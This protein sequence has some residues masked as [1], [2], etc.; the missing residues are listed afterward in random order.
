MVKDDLCSKK[1]KKIFL[2]LLFLVF[3]LIFVHNPLVGDDF[4]KQSGSIIK[5]F[6]ASLSLWKYFNG[7]YI[8]NALVVFF[9][10]YFGL[11]SIFQATIVCTIIYLLSNYKNEKKNSFYIALLLIVLIP[12]GIYRQAIAWLSGCVNFLIPACGFLA[13]FY[14]VNRCK[15]D[16]WINYLLAFL[17]SFLML[18]GYTEHSSIMSILIPIILI[19]FKK[20]MKEKV[21][22]YYSF[23]VIGGILGSLLM[24]SSPAYWKGLSRVSEEF[25]N[26][27]VFGKVFYTLS[28][29]TFIKDL[30]FKN[31]AF[32]MILAFFFLTKL[33]RKTKISNIIVTLMICILSFIIFPYISFVDHFPL[34][35]NVIV[36]LL[37]TLIYWIS[38]LYLLF[39][40]IN[41]KKEIIYLILF[42]GLAVFSATP[43]L[44][45]EG[46]GPRCF[47]NTYI[48]YSIFMIRLYDTENSISYKKIIK[49]MAIIVVC[50]YMCLIGYMTYQNHLVT[51]EREKNIRQN[52][53]LAIEL[54]CYKYRIILHQ[55]GSVENDY[56][57]MVFK[58]HY[59]ISDET[60]IVL[61]CSDKR[62]VEIF[63]D[64]VKSILK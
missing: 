12:V 29:T 6:N 64:K 28:E 16:S 25:A 45:A 15:K 30:T 14:M 49:L 46:I 31:T 37:L 8:G 21:Y 2:L 19:I 35:N 20:I 4:G 3:V 60:D 48:F 32:N 63:L 11:K 41:D 42:Y 7:R 51:L 34:F 54:P 40:N 5:G 17:I 10:E 57:V 47:F 23:F 59:G 9:K 62:M 56:H 50:M 24:F 44:L 13:M 36:S 61:K 27:S 33:N 52:D 26:L 38:I 18:N 55:G 22:N 58:M 1:V 43:L 53:S 39:T